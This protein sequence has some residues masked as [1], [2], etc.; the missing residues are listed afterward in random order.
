MRKFIIFLLCLLTSSMLLA[1]WSSNP[2]DNLKIFDE[3]TY[4]FEVEALEDGS[5]Y[6]MY[7]AP[8]GNILYY[9]MYYTKDGE[10]VWDKPVL[11]SDKLTMTYLLVNRYLMVDKDGNALVV[12]PSSHL[13]PDRMHETYTAYMFDKT[14]KALWG[15]DGVNLMENKAAGLIAHMQMVQ[16][17]DGSYVFAWTEIP[18]EGSF[19]IKM[20]RV[21]QSG[22]YVWSEAKVM[23]EEGIDYNYP[24]LV[25]SGNNEYIMV[26]SR[27]AIQELYAQKYDFDGNPIW[28]S[29]VLVYGSG[30]G[31]IPIWTFV[32][33]QPAKGGVLVTWY[34]DPDAD[35]IEAAFVSYIKSDGSYAYQSGSQGLQL[36]YSDYRKF[37]P[38]AVFNEAKEEVYAIWR[39][40]TPNQ[41]MASIRSQ[42]VSSSGELLWDA[43]GLTVV[44]MTP[45]SVGYY[46]AREDNRGNYVA[47]Y[48]L[49]H[50]YYRNVGAYAYMVDK[51]GK[52]VWDDTVC[53]SN[54][55]S[56][57]S[58]MMV[59]EFQADQWV[60]IWQDDRIPEGADDSTRVSMIY[61]QN[62]NF[63][64]TIGIQGDSSSI[65][66]EKPVSG[67][68][69]NL[70]A[71]PVTTHT[72]ISLETS[73]SGSDL[74]IE[75]YDLQGR[76]VD[77]IYI[78]QTRGGSFLIEWN[79][80]QDLSSGMY[81]LKVMSGH[82]VA[83]VKMIL[84]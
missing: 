27:G 80:D 31:S 33:V 5:F 43:E 75:L 72:T 30:F 38:S 47:F 74:K 17:E 24:Y 45:T 42:L 57:K 62:V 8:D 64:G 70:S 21:D 84:K 60:C 14:G 20:L 13:D 15:E 34:A 63:D 54:F 28:E 69:V 16:I 71:N 2:S 18:D 50:D 51:S 41:A 67:L 55:T 58:G 49:A 73:S 65:M 53:I 11:V 39:E 76:K 83:I 35:D 3:E 59:S 4:S 26:Y 78:G 68:S 22:D 12:V 9:L 61:G 79:R 25:N 29:P 77:D 19:T 6:V 32:D 82:E 52:P 36:G 40:T 66:P 44:P 7:N 37:T 81:L 1:Q 56:N 10:P 48:M 23:A 46:S